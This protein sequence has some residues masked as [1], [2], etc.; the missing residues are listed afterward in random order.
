M[1]R[2]TEG[3]VTN[4]RE[5]LDLD[6]KGHLQLTFRATLPLTSF[7]RDLYSIFHSSLININF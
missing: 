4:Q 3:E 5:P 6:F 7:R 2:S 1:S